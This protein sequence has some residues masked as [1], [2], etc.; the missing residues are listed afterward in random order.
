LQQHIHRGDI[1]EVNFCQEFYATVK[2]SP[3]QAYLKLQKYSPAPYSCILKLNKN[4]LLAASPERFL[5]KT[6]KKII[7]QPIKGTSE[8]NSNPKKDTLLK[9]SLRTSPKE[10]SE[11]IMIVDLV[12]NDLSR[13]AEPGSVNVDELCGVYSFEHVHQM[14]SSISAT[15]TTDSIN[16]IIRATFPMGSMTGAPK[17]NALKLAEDFEPVKRGIYSGAVGYITPEK[18]FDFN[19]VIRCIQYNVENMYLSYMVGG[20]ITSLSIAEDEYKECLIKARAME[21]LLRNN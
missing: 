9:E 4:Y 20:A 19:V 15:L 8:R 7:S 5:K 17:L 12:R 10:R 1:Y 18:D 21:V 11:N 16:Q 2:F 13:I 6:G 14:I 3:E